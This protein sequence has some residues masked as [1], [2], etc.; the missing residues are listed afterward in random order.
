MG[1]VTSFFRE[2]SLSFIPVYMC[3]DAL[4]VLPYEPGFLSSFRE[5]TLTLPS[6]KPGTT[7]QPA[8]RMSIRRINSCRQNLAK[9]GKSA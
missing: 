6:D 1:A 9:L 5:G 7:H 4:E 2:P 3:M 8:T